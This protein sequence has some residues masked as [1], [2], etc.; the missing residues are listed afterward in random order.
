ME[1][2]ISGRVAIIT[3]AGQ[4]I[5][6][7]IAM[8]LAKEGAAV[9]VND[10]NREGAGKVCGEIHETGGQAMPWCGDVSASGDVNLMVSEVIE[11]YGRIDI[12]VNNARITTRCPESLTLEEYWDRTLAVDL[13]G[14]Y[15]C[16]RACFEHMEKGGYGRIINISSAQA[17]I[18]KAEDDLIPYSSAKSGMHGL[19]RSFAKRGMRLGVTANIV[20]PDYIET[21]VVE[22]IWGKEA[23]DKTAATV[24]IGRPGKPID[25]VLAALFLIDSGFIT[26][27]TIFV[28]GGRFVAS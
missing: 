5:G 24:P 3:G 14:A 2:D 12:L 8:R 19:S 26:G 16:S 27:E 6:R 13:K 21:E 7:A 10:I 20:A 15:L 25:V 1:Y 11:R 22:E 18:G 4:G 17:Y 28:N 9:I 23:C